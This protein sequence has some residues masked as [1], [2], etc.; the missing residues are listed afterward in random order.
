M[1]KLQEKISLKLPDGK[2]ISVEKGARF[3]DVLKKYFPSLEKKALVA[4]LNEK[5]YDLYRE[6]PEEGGELKFL[7]WEEEEGKEVFWHSSAH[8]LAQAIKRLYPNAQLTIGPVIKNG[9]GFFYYD[10]YL[11]TPITEE[12]FPKIEKEIQKIIQAGYPIRRYVYP[13]EKAIQEFQEMGEHF[14]VKI[15]EEIPKEEILTVYKQGEWQD[16]CRGPHVPS[17]DRLGV[18]KLTS[19]AGAYWKGDPK[20]PVLQRIYGV[21]FPTKKELEEYLYK[22]EE[23][24]KR[25]HRKLGKELQLFT[26]YKD[27]PGFPIFL[28]KGNYILQKLIRLIQKECLKRG[29]EE[30][31]TP[32]LLPDELWKISGHYENF[33]EF[34]FFTE[35]EKRGYAIKPMN[36]PGAALV[37][38]SK[39]RSYKEL[40]LRLAEIGIVH[41]NELSGVLH[42]LLRLRAFTQ[43]DAHIFCEI[44]Q[45]QEEIKSLI[46]FTQE[47]YQIFGFDKVEIFV[48]TRP[49]KYAGTEEDWEKATSSLKKALEE[50]GLPYGIKEKEGA[51]YGPKIEFN[52]EDSLGRKWQCGTIQVDFSLPKRFSLEYMGKDGRLHTPVVI[53]R[54]I[55]GSFERFMGILIEHYGGKFPLW[56]SPEQIRI[57]TVSKEEMEYA[58]KIEETLKKKGYQVKVDY[59]DEKIGYK[60]R[61]WILEKGN[62]ALIIGKKEK[63]EKVI[64]YRRRGEKETHKASL[65]EFIKILEE[66]IPSYAKEL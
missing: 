40:P 14:K 65:E 42:G 11:D 44:S 38:L 22:I 49:D 9:P 5:L 12:D 61:Q 36:C 1:P 55:L 25:D 45:L 3:E 19:V 18:V 48:A 13:R 2:E 31:R 35:V 29:Y 15:I 54:A 50:V 51:F 21:S 6:I 64:S 59:R 24:K 47:V 34:M 37:Y 32:F 60:I 7:T 62:Y 23:A 17:T 66:E 4:K 10:I 46:L 41:R 27:A 20:N 58:K 8:A 39:E 43:D 33:R 26:F 53:H 57:L 28:P 30:I 56:L 16:L 52:I 63:E